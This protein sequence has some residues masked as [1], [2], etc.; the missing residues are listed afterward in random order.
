M[1]S[2]QDAKTEVLLRAAGMR[3]GEVLNAL[4]CPRCD[5]G[6]S[7]EQS[8]RVTKG[9]SG[10]VW[11]RCYRNKCG[12][13]G[14]TG[15]PTGSIGQTP[16]VRRAHRF[17]GSTALLTAQQL[18]ALYAKFPGLVGYDDLSEW[19]FARHYNRFIIPLKDST[20]TK[21]GVDAKWVDVLYIPKPCGP[22]SLIYYDNAE[23]VRLGWTRNDSRKRAGGVVVVVEDMISASVVANAGFDCVALLGT[24]LS[25]EQVYALAEQ[26]DTLVVALDPDAAQKAATMSTRNAFWFSNGAR[27]VFFDK[28]PKYFTTDEI[29]KTIERVV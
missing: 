20:L 28:D 25:N 24:S 23:Y 9:D 14:G 27:T 5:G 3:E 17:T 21:W 29:V 10:D 8:L 1:R 12:F 22:K 7:R 11:F 13:T 2:Y 15:H 4:V 6:T 26:H 18:A 19:R 16:R